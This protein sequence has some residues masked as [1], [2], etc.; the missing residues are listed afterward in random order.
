M[1]F[2]GDTIAP[3]ANLIRLAPSADVLVHEVVDV[4]AIAAIIG[5]APPAQ[6]GPLRAHL[7]N[8]HAVV[9]KVPAVAKAADARRVVMCHYIPAPVPPGV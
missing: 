9:R 6:Q 5:I 1:V 8:A 3:N 7:L 4:D 2:S